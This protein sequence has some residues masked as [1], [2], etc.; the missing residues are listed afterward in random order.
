M[1]ILAEMKW[2]ELD[3]ILHELLSVW[4]FTQLKSSKQY[5]VSPKLGALIISFFI[6][7]KDT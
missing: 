4:C 2:N 1:D 7:E 5:F 3:G 6:Y